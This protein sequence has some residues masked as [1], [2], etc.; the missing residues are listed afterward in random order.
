M[1][2]D[3]I[4]TSIKG[5][6]VEREYVMLRIVICEDE[7]YFADILKKQVIEY[8]KERRIVGDVT[9]YISGEELLASDIMPDILLMDIK[10][11]GQN[12]IKIAEELRREGKQ[13]QIMFITSYREYVFRAFDVEAVH[14]ILKPVDVKKL[15]SALHKAVKRA[16]C[17]K[18]DRYGKRGSDRSVL[19][20][21]GGT[22]SRVRVCD[23]VYCEVFDHQVLIHTRKETIQISGTLDALQKELDDNF[24]RCHRS[25]LINMDFVTDKEEGAAVMEGGEKVMISRR[26]RK[27]FM[28]R[29]LKSCREGVIS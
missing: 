16:E 17:E 9:V 28:K 8:L 2:Q 24:F 6:L 10:L 13:S 1:C 21:S 23:I 5:S 15:F 11:P 14:Y 22:A 12:G 3:V 27:E 18:N 29:L 7:I 26:K 19:L 25:Y 4:F 20:T